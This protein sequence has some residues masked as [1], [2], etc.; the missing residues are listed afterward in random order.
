MEKQNPI[1]EVRR[2]VANAEEVISHR[3]GMASCM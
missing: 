1:D 2:Y 3:D